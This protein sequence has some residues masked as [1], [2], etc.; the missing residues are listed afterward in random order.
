MELTTT[1]AVLEDNMLGG[2]DVHDAEPVIGNM[3][4]IGDI[5]TTY[6]IS[7]ETT[8]EVEVDNFN[9]MRD[10]LSGKSFEEAVSFLEQEEINWIK[11]SFTDEEIRNGSSKK[12]KIFLTKFLPGAYNSAKS[13]ILCALEQ[14]KP[15]FDA[16]GNPLGKT[17]MQNLVK[18]E[19][20]KS[21]EEK[22]N[23]MLDS[24]VKLLP[25][26]TDPEGTRDIMVAR[27][28]AMAFTAAAAT[29]TEE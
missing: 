27:L 22:I 23:T 2:S 10:L 17:A 6:R 11:S 20:Q 14:G 5:L 18:K 8:D 3:S 21:V 26:C 28:Q 19:N 16:D 4:N 24:I 15:M 13:V 29:E 25:S 7:K 9:N 1:Y 12:G